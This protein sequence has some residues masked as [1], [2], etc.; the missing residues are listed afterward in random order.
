MP[1][2]S[3]SRPGGYAS[4]PGMRAL[5]GLGH[6]AVDAFLMALNPCSSSLGFGD[7]IQDAFAACIA[8]HVAWAR[9][10][11]CQ[12][13]FALLAPLGVAVLFEV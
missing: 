12:H 6:P 11:V 13:V 5:D 3:Q 9:L 8:V 2:P 7:C 10:A 1:T 4:P